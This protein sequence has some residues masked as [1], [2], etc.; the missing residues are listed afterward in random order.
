MKIHLFFFRY[1]MIAA[2]MATAGNLTAQTIDLSKAE[3]LASPDILSPVRETAIRILQEEVEKRTSLKLSPATG[4]GKSP[5]I[6]LAKTN[7]DKISG[8]A[9]PKRSGELLPESQAE[10]F[11]IAI[12]RNGRDILWLIA[13]DE[14][15]VMFAIGQFLRTAELSLKK[16]SFSSINEIA[17]SPAY[18]IR[19]HQ[20]G[21]R[22]TANSWDA[23][24]ISQYEQ[25]IRELALFGSNCIE[26]IPFQDGPLGPNMTIPREEMNTRMSEICN[27]YGLDY[28]VWTPADV[29]LS[30]SIRFSD[31]VKKHAGFYK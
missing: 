7:D 11:R 20:L 13:A 29:D 3:I 31:E 4:N 5:L 28:W 2:L 18:P 19:G 9:V 25:Y 12:D 6:I 15:G 22:N 1:F 26:N 16:I 30:D 17:T 27:N 21:Y 24:T 10:G 8:I 23:W 14:R